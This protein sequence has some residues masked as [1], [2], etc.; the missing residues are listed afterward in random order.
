MKFKKAEKIKGVILISIASMLWGLDGVVLTPRLSNLNIV[1]V[2]F[3]LHTIPFILMNIFLFDRYK[4]ISKFEGKTLIALFLVSLFGGALGTIAIVKALFIV[5]FHQLSV[6]VLLQKLQPVFAII[7]AAIIL[8]E[9]LTRHFLFWGAISILAGYFLTFGISKPDL[10]ADSN[11]IKAALLSIFAAF[12]FGSSTVFSKEILKKTDFITA[13]FF[14][15]GTTF[16]LLL[17][18]VIFT[19]IIAQFNTVTTTNWIV[20]F[21]ISITTG[22]GA[23][24]LYYLGLKH[25]KAS[26]STI[27]ELFFPLTAIILDYYINGNILSPVQWLSAAI[28]IFSIIKANLE[29]VKV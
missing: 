3:I 24:F 2:V 25:V 20:I 21:I 9:K 26:I 17:P 10:H 23:I 4:D 15:Y 5:N 18:I 28:M 14:R 19:G 1:F 8:R 12:S 13:T 7:L 6:V 22:S 16:L 27:S 29:K 11:T